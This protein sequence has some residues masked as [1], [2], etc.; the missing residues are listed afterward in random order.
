M[1]T[2]ITFKNPLP[3]YRIM[4]LLEL[5][6]QILNI[7]YRKII[8]W[9]TRKIPTGGAKI[10]LKAGLDT[11]NRAYGKTHN[12]KNKKDSRFQLY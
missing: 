2:K 7:K 11:M 5:N 1:C 12:M 4:F 8:N 10:A 9:V 3:K 6:N